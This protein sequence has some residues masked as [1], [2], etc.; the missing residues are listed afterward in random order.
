MIKRLSSCIREYKLHSILSPIFI[1]GE[2]I[3][4]IYIPLYM[5]RLIDYGIDM[6]DMSY[7]LKMGALLAALCVLSLACGALSGYYAAVASVGFG[8]NL[9]HA[10]IHPGIH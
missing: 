7:V 6:G 3:L 5:G 2:V 10:H 4:D 8:A 1:T 9:D